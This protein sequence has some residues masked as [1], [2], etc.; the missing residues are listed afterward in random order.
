MLN[1]SFYW[2]L[3]DSYRMM[4]FIFGFIEFVNHFQSGKKDDVASDDEP[5]PSSFTE[6]PYN[7]PLRKTGNDLSIVAISFEVIDCSSHPVKSLTVNFM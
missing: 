3:V 7:I 1:D 4:L 6:S 2:Y 5:M